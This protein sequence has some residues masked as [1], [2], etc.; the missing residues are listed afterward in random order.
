M[1]SNSANLQYVQEFEIDAKLT[2]VPFET[3]INV[4]RDRNDRLYKTSLRVEE[5][6]VEMIERMPSIK[7]F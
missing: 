3:D 2:P 4:L 1:M 6:I 7:S 5:L